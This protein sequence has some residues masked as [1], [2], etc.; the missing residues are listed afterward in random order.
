MS[1]RTR[2]ADPV[3]VITV[4]ITVQ[5]DGTLTVTVDGKPYLPPEFSPPWRRS[6]YAVIVDAISQQT[7][8]TLRVDVI[9]TDGRTITD[10]RTPTVRRP[11]LSAQTEELARPQIV[12]A[13]A[14]Q[15]VSPPQL[16]QFAGS[17]MIPGEDVAVAII[18]AHTESDPE[19]I[20]R[21]LIDSRYLDHA[22]T[23]EVVLLGRISATVCVGKPQ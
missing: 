3:D 21:A 16:L 4:R 14:P 23:G 15:P 13:P 7:G 5:D 10:Y 22:P 1:K 8:K 12:A 18:I 2:A 17:G 6:S 20:A 11:E 19:G 9:E